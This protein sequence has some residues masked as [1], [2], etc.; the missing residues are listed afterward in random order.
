MRREGLAGVKKAAI[1]LMSLPAQEASSILRH[2]SRAEVE[3]IAAEIANTRRVDRD[4]QK[5]VL[6]EFY[7]MS[8][9]QAE[10][11]EGGI[12]AAR[13]LLERAFDPAR[14]NEILTRLTALMQRRPFEVLRKVDPAQILAF[15]QNEHPQTIAVLLAY[16]DPAQASQ[17]LSAL[18]DDLQGEV[19]RRIAVMDRVSPEMIKEIEALIEKRLQTLSV[20]VMGNAG[21]IQGLVPIL[22]NADRNA[23]R[24]ILNRLEADDPEL[25]EE[26]RA[27]MFVFE[28]IVQLD[29]RSIQKVLRRVD[30]KTLATALKGTPEEVS[31]KI[32]KN[33]SQKAAELLRDDM[34][35]MGPVRIRDVEQAQREVI[36][37]IRQL[38]DQGEIVISRGN[39]EDDYVV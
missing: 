5:A 6:E 30:N 14:A 21:G 24:T 33:L 38:E 29:D 8:L 18:P 39:E 25:A 9:A 17:V 7:Q 4:L 35:V 37:I 27:R 34:A 32:F 31:Q 36:H 1:L 2:L 11:A 20:E 23:E 19:A 13:A 28:N 12:E 26:V 3:K 10:I 16:M 15:I 22:S